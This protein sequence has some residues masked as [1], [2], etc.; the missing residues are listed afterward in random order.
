MHC[1]YL[2]QF[3]LDG[4]DGILDPF[5]DFGMPVLSDWIVVFPRAEE[6]GGGVDVAL[7]EDGV[8]CDGEEVA[9]SGDD[10]LVGI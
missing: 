10:G 4:G 6:R 2:E 3:R 7:V 8:D 9:E 5:A 1:T